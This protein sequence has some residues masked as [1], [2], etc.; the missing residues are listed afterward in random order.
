MEGAHDRSTDEVVPLERSSELVEPLGQLQVDVHG[1]FGPV[2]EERER[3]VERRECRSD[4]AQLGERTVA[5]RPGGNAVTDLVEVV[6]VSQHEGPPTRSSTS[7][8]IASTPTASAASKAASVFSGA[9]RAAP[10]WPTR[11]GGPS[12]LKSFKAQSEAE[13]RRVR[14]RAPR[15]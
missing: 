14:R 11:I 9:S 3:L 5:H 6:R 4:L 7:N 10:R 13:P 15:S 8:S 1:D 12:P 2:G